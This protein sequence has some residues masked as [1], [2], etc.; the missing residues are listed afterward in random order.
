MPKFINPVDSTAAGS[1]KTGVLIANLG[2]PDAP[3]AAAVRRYLAEFL[4][5]PRVVDLPRAIW[6][7]ILHLVI[8]PFRPKRAAKAYRKIWTEQGSPLLAISRRQAQALGAALQAAM[9]GTFQ[10]AL[11]MRYGQPSIAKA[12]A[13]MR[14]AGVQRLLVL[15]LYPQYSGTST[16]SI[17]DAVTK[18][19][20]TWRVIPELR[21][22]SHYY[23]HAGYIEAL[24]N[25]MNEYWQQH[26]APERTLFSFHG[27]PKRLVR[28]GDPY[29]EQCQQTTRLLTD[30]LGLHKDQWSLG[31]QSRFGR[32]EWLTPDV[33]S[34]LT[35]WARQGIRHVAVVCPGFSVDCL[36]TLEEIAI[37]D[38]ALFLQEGGER[39]DY[40]PALNDRA[41]HIHALTTL[42]R[43]QTAGWQ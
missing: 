5:D 7:L 37:Q 4:W 43:K 27:L 28:L 31:F 40:I 22:I 10:V 12:M 42:I 17:M 18:V 36:E 3:T 6:W 1:A 9:P 11:G 25:S 19:L 13:E 38:R 20:S 32:E 24:A 2:T 15:P 14:M 16:A 30:R 34:I 33:I 35:Q 26:G 29:Y 23:D 41:D 39:F 8:L 21:W